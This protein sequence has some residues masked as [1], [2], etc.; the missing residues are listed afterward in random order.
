MKKTFATLLILALIVSVC[1]VMFASASDPVEELKAELE[2]LVGADAEDAEFDWVMNVETDEN[3]VV[4]VVLTLD[5]VA[6]DNMTGVEGCLYYDVDELTLLTG[7]ADGVDADALDCATAMPEDFE[8]LCTVMQDNRGNI[9]PGIIRINA[10]NGSTHNAIVDED[11]LVFTL[12]FQLAEG[13]TLAGLY[14]TTEST[15]GVQDPF[16]PVL[17]NGAYGIAML[18]VEEESS[19][20]P[21]VEPSEAPSVE[22]SEEPSV[23]P[24]EEPS[25]E[26]SAEPSQPAESSEAPAPGDN[27]IL[28]FVALGVLAVAGAAVALKVRG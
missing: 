9:Y 3:G 28:L 18:E 15:W 10:T 4:T 16:V 27:G 23:E 21:S 19:E 6:G 1:G 14:I 26:P 24:S 11:D 20:E 22:S 13:V 25:E 17:G 7:N 2:A 12:Q 5:G 8:N